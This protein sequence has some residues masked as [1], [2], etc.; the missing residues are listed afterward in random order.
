MSPVKTDDNDQWQPNDPGRQWERQLSNCYCDPRWHWLD[1][2]CDPANWPSWL[3]EPSQTAQLTVTVE[4]PVLLIIIGIDPVIDWTQ[5]M[6][7]TNWLTN[8]PGYCGWL[9]SI[10]LIVLVDNWRHYWPNDGPSYCWPSNWLTQFI[11]IIVGLAKRTMDWPRQRQLIIENWR[12]DWQTDPDPDW[13]RPSGNDNDG[14]G[15]TQTLARTNPAGWRRRANEP[16]PV[17]VKLDGDPDRPAKQPQPSCDPVTDDW[18]TLTRRTDPVDGIDPMWPVNLL[19]D[20]VTNID[21]YYWPSIG[22][23]IIELTQWLLTQLVNPGNWWLLLRPTDP[24]TQPM[25]PVTDPGQYW[26]GRPSSWLTVTGRWRTVDV[27]Y[28]QPIVWLNP[29]D[30]DRRTPVT[31]EPSGQPVEQTDPAQT[32]SQPARRVDIIDGPNC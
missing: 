8:D 16:S 13:W 23:V 27:G 12:T 32:D 18:R 15:Q 29:M 17:V 2:Y 22:T 1:S 20:P 5:L 26:P 30:D 9:D 31:G 14:D 4:D 21:Y 6:T 11:I 19:L 24:M 3:I 25:N 28:W 7:Q 10:V